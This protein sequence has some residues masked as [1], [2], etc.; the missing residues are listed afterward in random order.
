MQVGGKAGK[1]MTDSN[2]IVPTGNSYKSL[3]EM[4]L[5]V[6]DTEIIMK[7]NCKLCN[8]DHRAD[9]ETLFD[10]TNR[11]QSV[12]DL[13]ANRGEKISFKA[14]KNHL[15]QH[16]I[17]Q[18]RRL[19]VRDYAVHLQDYLKVKGDFMDD[20]MM[21]RAIIRK[22]LMEIGSESNGLS[23]RDRTKNTELLTK[24]MG[25]L[26]LCAEQERKHK[27]ET[28]L[29]EVMLAKLISIVDAEKLNAPQEVQVRLA[30]VVNTLV[31]NM[32]KL[33]GLK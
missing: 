32:E 28:H 16:Y 14:V 4:A 7:S 2:D 11:F 30:K 1:Q 10:K 17:A 3:Q 13:L 24:L 33:E 19:R 25:Q 23:S 12:V 8:S 29:A 15:E 9:A 20:L 21:C 18:E 22:E 5:D 26:M 27:G 6:S 31:D